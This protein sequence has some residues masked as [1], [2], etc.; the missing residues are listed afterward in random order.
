[1]DSCK[2]ENNH[3]RCTQ[4]SILKEVPRLKKIIFII[5]VL[6]SIGTISAREKDD[7]GDYIYDTWDEFYKYWNQAAS[8]YSCV[9]IGYFPHTPKNEILKLI[10]GTK[11]SGFLRIS[12]YS[13]LVFNYFSDFGILTACFAECYVSEGG[14]GK[15]FVLPYDKD[16]AVSYW[17]TL[18][19]NM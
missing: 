9:Y 8:N 6:F 2:Y 15:N 13:C 7:Q 14:P 12:G 1:M 11:K 17:N 10:S 5:V 3:F 19:D 18:I 4:K 16:K